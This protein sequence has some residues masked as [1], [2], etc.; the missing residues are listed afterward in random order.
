MVES[1]G[2]IEGHC[3]CGNLSFLMKT[4]HAL[5]ELPMRACDC[6][7]CRRHGARCTSD[8]AGEVVFRVRDPAKLSRYRFG[9]E[10][11]D[12]LIC[13]VCGVYAGAF[14]EVEG[15]QRATVNL[16]LTTL[17]TRRAG[18][19]DYAGESIDERIARRLAR[20]TPAS[21]E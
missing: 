15:Q 8:P 7:F 11:A 16:N 6:N 3:H 9:L 17:D 12:F 18:S 20:W 5:D 2:L 19:V 10:T 21:I 13:D 14:I 1:S 4:R